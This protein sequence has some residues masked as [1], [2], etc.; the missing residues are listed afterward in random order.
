MKLFRFLG[1][2]LLFSVAIQVFATENDNAEVRDH[3]DKLRDI[4]VTKDKA[5]I[6]ELN[7]RMDDAWAFIRSHPNSLPIVEEDLRKELAT[8]EPDQFFIMDVGFLVVVE[9][10]DKGAELAVAAL[11]HVNLT[12]DIIHANWEELFHFSMKL[13]ATGKETERYLRQMDRIYLPNRTE[14]DFFR[15]PHV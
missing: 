15:A 7:K 5:K 13:G 3:L 6:A 1:I 14:I 12:S 10:G 11:E 8:K 4:H 2:A 9:E